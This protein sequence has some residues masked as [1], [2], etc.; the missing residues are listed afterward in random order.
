MSRQQ[1][2]SRDRVAIKSKFDAEYRRFSLLLS[3]TGCFQD[4]YQ[5]LRSIHRIPGLEVFLEYVDAHGDLLPINNDENFHKALSAARPL[6][7]VILQR[8]DVMDS[9]F[10][11]DLPQRKKKGQ[12][13]MTAKPHPPML[14]GPPK[15]F[16]PVSSI[17][18]VDILPVTLRRVRL[19]KHGSGRPLGFYIRDGLSV[20]VTP[21]GVEKVPGIFISRVVRGGLAESTGLLGLNDEILEVNDID[22]AG[23]SLD[24]VT[25]M[26]VANSRNLVITVKPANQRNNV[27]RGSKA[28]A[29]SVDSRACHDSAANPASLHQGNSNAAEGESDEEDSD[30]I[31]ENNTLLPRLPLQPFVNGSALLRETSPPLSLGLQPLPRSTT[32]HNSPTYRPGKGMQEDGNI[33]TL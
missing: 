7:R 11:I 3:S 22:V 4:F 15:D 32:P 12:R 30:I 20:R 2:S 8:K 14:I 33:I 17:I 16:R 29:D 10:S 21:Q 25:D 26:M 9:V 19:H 23:K 5:L 1:R 31:I 27:V 24:Q 28:S 6:L 18:D 13:Q